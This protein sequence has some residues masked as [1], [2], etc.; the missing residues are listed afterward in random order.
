[1]ICSHPSQEVARFNPV[2]REAVQIG[3]G[4]RSNISLP[5]LSRHYHH[6][7][8]VATPFNRTRQVASFEP[9]ALT[10]VPIGTLPVSGASTFLVP[11]SQETATPSLISGP[12]R[13]TSGRSK[14]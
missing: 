2:T 14:H 6:A 8:A 9:A 7:A 10:H 5:T 1:M 13:K 11:V 3:H 12:N 4:Q